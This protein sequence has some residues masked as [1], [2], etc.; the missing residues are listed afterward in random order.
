MI[1]APVD[2]PRLALDD[3]LMFTLGLLIL[4]MPSGEKE[5]AK[6]GFSR[7]QTLTVPSAPYRGKCEERGY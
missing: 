1:Y 4:L 6:E 5:D 3:A 7:I 2:A